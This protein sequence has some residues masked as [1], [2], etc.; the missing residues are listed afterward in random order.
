MKIP[1]IR[2]FSKIFQYILEHLFS[3]NNNTLIIWL[4]LIVGT[5]AGIASAVFHIGIEVVMAWR[6]D[7]NAYFANGEFPLWLIAIPISATMVGIAFYITHRYAPEAGGSG[8]PEIE[9]A[10]EE[11]RPV[12]WKRVIPVKFF[13]GLMALG[14]G[15][16]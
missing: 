8:I 3:R 13:G 11:M 6:L 1:Q 16:A 14:S 9:G 5:L 10:M 15:M 7:L 4:S 2:L 12:R